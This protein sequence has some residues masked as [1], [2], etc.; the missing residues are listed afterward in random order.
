M[1]MSASQQ[2]EIRPKEER[3]KER[4]EERENKYTN[5]AGKGT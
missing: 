4:K 1:M 3:L 5:F 2:A